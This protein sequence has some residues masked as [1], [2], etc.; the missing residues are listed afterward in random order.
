[1]ISTVCSTIYP[2]IISFVKDINYVLTDI[3]NSNNLEEENI[4]LLSKNIKDE[5]VSF[6][7]KNI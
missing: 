7:F 6:K 1:M 4:I 2:V 5:K 3:L